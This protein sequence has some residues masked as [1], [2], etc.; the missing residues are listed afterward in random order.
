MCQL[1]RVITYKEEQYCSNSYKIYALMQWGPKSL[2]DEIASRSSRGERMNEN[3][4]WEVLSYCVPTLA[5]LQ[6]QA[7]KHQTI[8]SQ[9]IL[10]QP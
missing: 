3:E 5:Y 10:R 2:R 8:T 1:E 9:S 4:L 7:M 6:K